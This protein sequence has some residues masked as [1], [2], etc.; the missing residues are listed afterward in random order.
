MKSFWLILG[1]TGQ[2]MFASRFL[3]QWIK[4]EIAGKSYIPTVFWYLSILGSSLLLIYAIYKRDPV[5]ILGQSMGMIVYT[6]NLILI[7]REKKI[8]NNKV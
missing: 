1:F 7:G 2:A 3:V 8:A 5:F 4:S 6:R